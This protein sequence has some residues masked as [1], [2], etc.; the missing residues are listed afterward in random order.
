[1]TN[2]R[3][4]PSWDAPAAELAHPRGTLPHNPLLMKGI[5]MGKQQVSITLDDQEVTVQPLGPLVARVVDPGLTLKVSKDDVV[6]LSHDP[7]D[8]EPPPTMVE[9]VHRRKPVLSAIVFWTTNN[10]NRMIALAAVLGAEVVDVDERPDE[11]CGTI[12]IAHAQDIDMH[13][14]AWAAGVSDNPFYADDEEGADA[15]DDGGGV[16]NFDMY[17]QKPIQIPAFIWDGGDLRPFEGFCR[18]GG[19]ICGEEKDWE[20]PIGVYTKEGKYFSILIDVRVH[21]AVPQ[22]FIDEEP[23][24]FP[25]VRFGTLGGTVDPDTGVLKPPPEAGQRE[26]GQATEGA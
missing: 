24:D 1:M 8:A 21:C 3:A 23:F 26:S 13:A 20:R 10:R 16:P 4:Q 14:I 11:E 12:R 18:G 5:A 7:V 22:F 2:R 19:P 9:I 6:R 17:F 15:D 25:I